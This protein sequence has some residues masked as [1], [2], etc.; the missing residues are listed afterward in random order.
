MVYVA[1]VVF[2]MVIRTLI[3]LYYV[4]VKNC[5]IEGCMCHY[6]MGSGFLNLQSGDIGF[7]DAGVLTSVINTTYCP[8]C[9]KGRQMEDLTTAEEKKTIAMPAVDVIAFFN[10]LLKIKG[11]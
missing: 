10:S 4:V 3:F 5:Q 11:R 1:I 6:C 7:M 2:D 8:Y 9:N